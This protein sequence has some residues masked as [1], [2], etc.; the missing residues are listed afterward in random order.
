[1]NTLLAAQLY[2]K[3]RQNNDYSRP[4]T[5][6]VKLSDTAG[7]CIRQRGPWVRVGDA[8]IILDNHAISI[9]D[10]RAALIRWSL[11]A[12]ELPTCI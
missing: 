8:A 11:P 10:V 4:P 2:R 12:R 5:H 1:M 7:G 3:A 9:G 6:N